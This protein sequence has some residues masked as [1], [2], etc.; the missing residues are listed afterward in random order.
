ME[1]SEKSQL[2]LPFVEHFEKLRHKP[3]WILK[4]LAL[5]VIGIIS[6][7]IGYKIGFNPE[8]LKEK[9]L[10]Q[11]QV[12]IQ[13]KIMPTISLVTG[14]IVPIFNSLIL[15]VIFLVISKICKA[16]VNVMTLFSASLSYT[17]II[18]VYSLIV[19]LINFFMGI[20]P[21]EVR[22]DSLNIFDKGNS[23]LGAINLE[24]FIKAI[25]TGIVYF[26]TSH[27]S[28]KT[29]IILSIITFVILVIMGITDASASNSLQN[30]NK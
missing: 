26:S 14:T 24:I 27:L 12:D 8:V 5:I 15:F 22:I 25:L 9:N 3:K 6:G 10:N 4:V 23:F 20:N 30:I 13:M 19:S 1:N 11:N 16:D 28:K 18:S 29:A 21:T 7:Y 17:L 2:N